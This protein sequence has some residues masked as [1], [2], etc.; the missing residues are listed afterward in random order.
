MTSSRLFKYDFTNSDLL[1]TLMTD[2]SVEP[3]LIF[4]TGSTL[5]GL[6]DNDS[7]FDIC[8][9]TKDT[10]K[11]NH[12]LAYR[13][14][15]S[16]AIHRP[17]GKKCHWVYNTLSQI[18]APSEF[19][20]DNIGWAQFKYITEDAIL[21]CNPK[22]VTVVKYLFDHCNKIVLNSIYLALVSCCHLL[23]IDVIADLSDKHFCNVK[24][25]AYHLCG[26]YNELVLA[27]Q[28]PGTLFSNEFISRIK[29]RPFEELTALEQQHI[30]SIPVAL[31]VFYENYTFIPIQLDFDI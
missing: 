31:S 5:T 3:I 1:A 18:N 19:M 20:L 21:Y 2:I 10:I 27:N 24:K 16:Y 9:L 22:Y 15:K 6:A 28:I 26:L 12:T 23:N 11:A 14:K 8:V 13:P 30:L 4:L 17:T 29:R 25:L 7:D